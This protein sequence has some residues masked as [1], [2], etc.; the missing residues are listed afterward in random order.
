MSRCCG[1]LGALWM[2]VGCGST[3]SDGPEP[4]A[5]CGPEGVAQLEVAQGETGFGDLHDGVSVVY[6]QPPQGGSPYAPFRLRMSGLA[7]EAETIAVELLATQAGGDVV[8]GTGAFDQR[9]I[10]S[11]VGENSGFLMG[12]ELHMRFP[13]YSL[14]D[15]DGQAVDA[16]VTVTDALGTRLESRF[17]GTLGWDGDTGL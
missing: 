8:L 10:C 5:E 4:T 2:I 12:S 17:S 14:S 7:Y 1:V 3:S 13:G 16:L 6:G 15:L 9:F 11:N